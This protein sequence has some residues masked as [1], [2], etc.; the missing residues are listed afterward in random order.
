MRLPV[1]AF[2]FDEIAPLS[3]VNGSVVCTFLP[4]IVFSKPSWLYLFHYTRLLAN[5]KTNVQMYYEKKKVFSH[6]R[7][8]N[9]KETRKLNATKE[10]ALEKMVTVIWSRSLMS[11]MG[12]INIHEIFNWY[13]STP[14]IN[15]QTQIDNTNI[16]NIRGI[17]PSSLLF[18]VL[19]RSLG[20]GGITLSMDTRYTDSMQLTRKPPRIPAKMLYGEKEWIKK[21]EISFIVSGRIKYLFQ[22]NQAI[23]WIFPNIDT[24]YVARWGDIVNSWYFVKFEANVHIPHASTKPCQNIPTRWK[25]NT[26]ATESKSKT[27]N[28]YRI[29]F[30][31][32]V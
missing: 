12:L 25:A 11:D 8:G 1:C 26:R 5:T 29:W 2:P 17:F 20:F 6:F 3:I 32:I 31:K 21:S 30:E 14:E 15:I 16:I 27:T 7:N 10:K 28:N 13:H 4:R 24:H 18:F 22:F 23:C 9:G 19:F